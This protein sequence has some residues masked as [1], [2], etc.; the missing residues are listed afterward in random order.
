MTR[1]HFLS[2]NFTERGVGREGNEWAGHDFLHLLKGH[3]LKCP[4]HA[5]SVGGT[6]ERFSS[7]QEV[8]SIFGRWG[9]EILREHF[10]VNTILVP[11]P[12]STTTLTHRPVPWPPWDMCQAVQQHL[13]SVRVWPGLRLKQPMESWSK[14][15]KR[16]VDALAANVTLAGMVLRQSS[17]VI[18]DDG[19]TTGGHARVFASALAAAG[20]RVSLALFASRTINEMSRR[21]PNA[22]DVPPE[23]F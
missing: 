8:L 3:P 21:V 6:L 11:I 22:F 23:D 5:V 10:L 7:R 16:D 12:S 9:A 20:A 4:P 18:V 19:Y 13:A 1:A 15:N 2:C 17:Y 14:T